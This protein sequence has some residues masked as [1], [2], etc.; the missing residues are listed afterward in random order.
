MANNES[1]VFQIEDDLLLAV[2][3]NT[4]MEWDFT[5][6]D[7]WLNHLDGGII[8]DAEKFR[9]DDAVK[10]ICTLYH[11]DPRRAKEIDEERFEDM[12]DKVRIQCTPEAQ[13]QEAI[14][15][16]NML[17][18]HPDVIQAYE[19]GYI[20]QSQEPYGALYDISKEQQAKISSLEKKYDMKVYHVIHGS[21]E[22]YTDEV[23][24]F[25]T[26]L[27]VSSHP[28]E[29]AEDRSLLQQGLQYSYVENILDEHLSE[30]GLI[31]MA[32]SY[33][34]L[35]RNDRG[36][37]FGSMSL[38]AEEMAA[39]LNNFAEEYDPYE[40]RDSYDSKEDGYYRILQDL[41]NNNVNDIEEYLLDIKGNDE[42]EQFVSK[43]DALL[44]ELSQFDDDMEADL[45][46]QIFLS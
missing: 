1:G 42:N 26:Y 41:L 30:I 24:S 13:K 10:E 33:G 22:F 20:C 2:H 31:G 16:M 23:M 11:Y 28:E 25:N 4:D 6:Y 8:G 14:D 44:Q 3:L 35:T 40:Y 7:R 38:T 27:Y 12:L 45:S 5:L 39:K 15:R 32:P 34:G 17:H 19:D 46:D 43:A 29:W 37:D 9:L 21:Y 18:L 36:Y